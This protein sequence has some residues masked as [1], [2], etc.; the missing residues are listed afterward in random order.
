MFTAR[1]DS[2]CN[3]D[4]CPVID[5]E[6]T[7]PNT[8]TEG[9]SGSNTNWCPS[10]GKCL[11]SNAGK[12]CPIC[13]TNKGTWCQKMGGG[14]CNALSE[15]ELEDQCSWTNTYSS[16]IFN[17]YVYNSRKRFN[18]I[19]HQPLNR[20]KLIYVVFIEMCWIYNM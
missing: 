1:E 2:C 19:F 7:Q 12:T 6:C 4:E 18:K 15:S 9:I 11:S 20:L 16:G 8:Y 5:D 13:P 3:Y 17:I 10:T 14:C